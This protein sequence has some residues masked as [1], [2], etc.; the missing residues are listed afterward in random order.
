LISVFEEKVRRSGRR[1]K[2][3]RISR[4]ATTISQQRHQFAV[5][6]GDPVADRERQCGGVA[7]T[8]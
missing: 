5:A 1:R 7:I 4:H 6:P 8:A 2:G 3:A